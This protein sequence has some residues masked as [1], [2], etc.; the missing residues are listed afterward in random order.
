MELKV[1]KINK[2]DGRVFPCDKSLSKYSTPNSTNFP[3]VV[4]S[5][6][7]YLHIYLAQHWSKDLKKKKKNTNFFHQALIIIIITNSLSFYAKPKAQT[8]LK[9][10]YNEG[11]S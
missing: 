11:K 6:G 7:N 2:T 1:E 8:T 4:I 10:N 9:K 3:E 5:K